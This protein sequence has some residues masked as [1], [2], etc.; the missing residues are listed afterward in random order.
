MLGILSALYL[1]LLVKEA[2]K[3]K[4]NRAA[5][6]HVIHVNGTRGKSSVT[7]LID[8]GLRGGGLRCFCKTTG[9]L[10][11]IIDCSGTERD[12]PRR[13]RPNIREQLK[14]LEMAAKDK[15]QV[16]VVECMAVNPQLQWISQHRILQA[17]CGVIT[18]VRSDHLDVMGKTLEEIALSMSSTIPKKGL[19]FTADQRFFPFFTRQCKQLDTVPALVL[20]T[21]QE[22]EL[23]FGENIA[24]ALAVCKSLGVDESSALAG[25]RQHYKRDPYALS[26]YELDSGA[27]AIGGFSI[28]DPDSTASVYEKLTKRDEFAGHRLT[29]LINNRPDRSFRTRQHAQ[30]AA[31]LQP[32]RVWVV[33]AGRRTMG[34]RIA[35]ALPSAQIEAFGSARSIPLDRLGKEDCLYC[36]GNLAREGLAVMQRLEK[37]GKRLVL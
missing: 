7:R 8:S 19:F 26:F 2:R 22:P 1:A 14:V 33:G 28:N 37:E 10:P 15:A 16:L 9:T 35:R 31:K 13:G 29:L 36:I 20:P 18:N 21:G 3:A 12:L 6:C 17:D 23:D 32:D 11:R 34:R 27:V 25:M 5:L 4:Q 30:L 24:L